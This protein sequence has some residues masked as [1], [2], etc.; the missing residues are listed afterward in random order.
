MKAK[1]LHTIRLRPLFLLL[2]PVFYLLHAYA[3]NYS[4]GLAGTAIQQAI[5]FT[6]TGMLISFLFIPI[7]KKFR[8]AALV[9]LFLV[10]FNFFFGILHDGAKDLLGQNIFLV[11]YMFIIGLV[12]VMLILLI[13]WLRNT[14][15]N[16][17]R[18]YQYLNV[19][20]FI[21]ILFELANLLPAAL[22]KKSI[23]PRDLSS[24]IVSCDTCTKPDVYVIIA[25]EYAGQK[26]LQD[27]FG[28]DNSAFEQELQNRGFHI[29][30]NSASNYNATVYSMASLFSMDHIGLS[31][32][33][34]VTQRDMLLCRSILNNNNTGRFFRSRGYNIYN[35]SFFDLQG[36]KQ[37]VRNYY[38]HPKSRILSF[39][40]FIN[41]FQMDAGFNFF[42]KAKKEAV[43]KNDLTNDERVDSLLRDLVRQPPTKPRFVYTHFT[44]PHHPY[45]VD[46]NGRPFSGTDSLRGF[47]R[48]KFEYT[49]HL[50]YTNKR[51]LQLIDQ[52]T[53][54]SRQ[55]PVI[56]LASDHGFR[57]YSG[58][59]DKKYYFMNLCAVLL[60][61][62]KYESFYE[63][64]TTVNIFRSIL[65]T[66]FGQRLPMLKDSTSFLIEKAGH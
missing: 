49:E 14:E 36:E 54:T 29:V 58:D 27:I 40:T 20:L 19:A 22:M 37:A 10:A 24:T 15:H 57:Q 16:F 13:L 33:N 65:N 60:P 30:D 62:R 7:V 52:V 47:E 34:L 3:E 23:H 61:D 42:S 44:R 12:M 25:D 9:G 6:G 64:M 56:L 31:G 35:Y 39:G 38:F 63:G 17:Y 55:P 2:L 5:L 4:P 41:R 28:F 66:Q 59:V 11:K 50:L 43:E 53:Q 32:G 21:L 48:I 45:Y 1:L 26:T 46:R 51:L 18:T 8:K